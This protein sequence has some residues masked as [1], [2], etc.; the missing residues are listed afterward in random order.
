MKAKQCADCGAYRTP[1]GLVGPS[2]LSCA[3]GRGEVTREAVLALPLCALGL[4]PRA[5]N[6]LRDNQYRTPRS[7]IE[8]VGDLARHAPSALL[9][10]PGFGKVSLREVRETLHSLRLSLAKE[11]KD[12]LWTKEPAGGSGYY[13]HFDP[14]RAAHETFL[15]W[16]SGEEARVFGGAWVLVPQ[17]GFWCGPLYP[18]ETPEP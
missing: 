18:P 7:G 4:S 11:R 1:E 16:V 2:C 13:W 10:L 12:S 5:Y 15:L 17:G 14:T 8:T 6:A 3:F 9:A